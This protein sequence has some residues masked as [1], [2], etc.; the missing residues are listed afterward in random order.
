MEVK[1]PIDKLAF[2]ASCASWTGFVAFWSGISSFFMPF[3]TG[4]GAPVLTLICF[5]TAG[6]SW[7]FWSRIRCPKCKVRL[8][9]LFFHK[10]KFFSRAPTATKCTDC[11]QDLLLPV[12]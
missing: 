12:K 4:K 3:F 9:N 10:G 8:W 5:L 1:R 6:L 7:F 11:G 2:N